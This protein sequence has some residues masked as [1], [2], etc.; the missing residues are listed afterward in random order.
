MQSGIHAVAKAHISNLA[1]LKE[2]LSFELTEVAVE[3]R[4]FW[5]ECFLIINVII[6]HLSVPTKG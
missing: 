2:T 3:M 5:L 6:L 4:L 1:Q